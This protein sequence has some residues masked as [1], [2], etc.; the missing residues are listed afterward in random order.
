MNILATA[1]L[2]FARERVFTAFRDGLPELVPHLPNV[3]E[4]TVRSRTVDDRAV[5]LVQ[6]WKARADLPAPVRV[7]LSEDRLHWDHHGTWDEDTYSATWRLQT[8]YGDLIT[9]HGTLR[10]DT[11]AAASTRITLAGE[12]HVDGARIPGVPKLLAR[13]VAPVVETFL[14]AGIKPNLLALSRG[15]EQYLTQKGS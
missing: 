10:F 1:D 7:L 3:R 12:L 2:P 13:T 5:H 15:V 4:I 11:A 14:V 9:T 6:H 8:A